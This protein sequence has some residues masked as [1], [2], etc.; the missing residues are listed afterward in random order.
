M[1]KDIL[2]IIF[3]LFSFICSKKRFRIMISL[4]S[5]KEK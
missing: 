5:H 1:I 3:A 2:F 4:P